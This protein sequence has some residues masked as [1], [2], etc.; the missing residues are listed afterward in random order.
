MYNN[1]NNYSNKKLKYLI[2]QPIIIYMKSKSKHT[3]PKI[4]KRRFPSKGGFTRFFKDDHTQQEFEHL[5]MQVI[6]YMD[7]GSIP[8]E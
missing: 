2:F 4:R 3:T 5:Q 1:F 6:A 8:W 7:D